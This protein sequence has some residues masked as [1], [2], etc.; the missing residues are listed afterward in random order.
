MTHEET[1]PAGTQQLSDPEATSA[2]P[3]TPPA[4]AIEQFREIKQALIGTEPEWVLPG[5]NSKALASEP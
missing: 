1:K 2:T 3:V 5:V 4:M